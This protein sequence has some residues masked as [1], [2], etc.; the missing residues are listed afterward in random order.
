MIDRYQ[1]QQIEKEA[2]RDVRT[3][4]HSEATVTSNKK[5]WSELKKMSPVEYEA[6]LAGG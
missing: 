5:P 1:H 3:G 4:P 2:R 6:Y